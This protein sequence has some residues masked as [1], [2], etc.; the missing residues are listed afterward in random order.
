[1]DPLP[2]DLLTSTR[3]T[4]LQR[5]VGL[6][7]IA[8]GALD[9]TV[10]AGQEPASVVKDSPLA[11]KSPPLPAKAKRVLYLSMSGAPPQHDTFDFKPKLQALDGTPCPEALFEGKRLAFIKGH[12]KLLASPHP[13]A[14]VD[15]LGIEV[16]TLLPGFREYA[17]D[18]CVVRSMYTDQFNH[19]PADLLMHTGNA[20][21]GKPSMGAWTTWGL[22]SM[23]QNLPGFVVLGS[24]GSDPTGGKALWSSGFLPSEY[25]GVRLR[26]KGDPVLYVSDPKGLARS[27][28]RRMLDALRRLNELDHERH[29]DDETMA[30]VAQYELAY[31][32]QM[33]VP[34]VTDLSKE[35]DATLTRYG[36]K[37]G[38]G[39]FASNCLLARNLLTAGVRFVQLFDWG[40]DLHGTGSND[41]LVTQFPAKCKEVDQ[42]IAALMADLKRTGLLEDTLVIWGGEFGRTPMLEARGGS[43]FLGRDHQPDAFSIW[44][45]GGGVRAG[46]VHGSTDDL[47]AAVHE[48]GVSVRDLQATILHLLGFDPERMRFPFQGLEQ[49]LIGPADGPRV[50]RGV[51]A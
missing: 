35:S 22:G 2:E 30:R 27:S 1:M 44:M 39:S 12:P 34:E 8:L 6:G 14:P 17:A 29:G 31:R 7:A 25:Q 4:F 18:V 46:H 23:N 11:P 19:A 20:V 15:P 41:D 51:L 40:W 3:R 5:G 48:D 26:S 36:A 45:A 43:K 33:E 21:T 13:T 32:M 16:S 24:G 47:G 50:A 49:R 10:V 42:P 37:P 9:G 28:R 38:D